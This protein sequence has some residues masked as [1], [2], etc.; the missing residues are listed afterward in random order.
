MTDKYLRKLG[1]LSEPGNLSQLRFETLRVVNV[2]IIL[3]LQMGCGLEA[4]A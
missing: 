3:A 2:I 1:N 4:S